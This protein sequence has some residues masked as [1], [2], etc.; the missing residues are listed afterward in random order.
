VTRPRLGIDTATPFLSV[1][2]LWPDDGR[3][4]R[5]AWRLDR[6][7]AAALAP[8]LADF[9]GSA[10]LTPRSLGGVGVGIG[11]G[12]YTG[13]RVGVAWALAVGRACDLPVVGGDTL[14]ARARATVA[15]GTR[16]WV[17]VAARRGEAWVQPWGWPEGAFA[18]LAAPRALPL[19]DLPEGA[20]ASLEVP[21]DAVE[22]ARQVDRPGAVAAAVRYAPA[23]PSTAGG[24]AGAAAGHDGT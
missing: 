11:P 17:A 18:P 9:L 1:A 7:L 2:L 14:A 4:L 23:A 10:G 20:G 15:V 5:A 6:A 8:R 22:H 19:A 21:P 24:A 12:S 16:G 13:A 3:I